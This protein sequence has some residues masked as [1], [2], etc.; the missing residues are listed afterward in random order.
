MVQKRQYSKLLI[1]MIIIST[2]IAPTL[3][4]SAK[5]FK[6]NDSID[7][8]QISDQVIRFEETIPLNIPPEYG[9]E[10]P[11]GSY[12]KVNVYGVDVGPGIILIDSGDETLAKELYKSVK[13]AFKEPILAVYLTHGHA[14]HAEGGLYFQEKGIPVYAYSYEAPIIMSGAYDP[15][16]PVPEEF[17]YTGYTPDY[18]YEYAVVADGFTIEYTPG[19]T[20]GS[21][22]IRYEG[23][24]ESYL[25][26]GDSIF[27]MP[28]MDP[29]DYSFTLSWYTAYQLWQLSSIPGYPDFTGTWMMS[30][31]YL[32]SVVGSV[33]VI[34]PGHGEEYSS[35][36]APQYLGLT[37]LVLSSLPYPPAVP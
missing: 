36:M 32:G 17:T 5:Q 15:E 24:C 1:S 23:E 11:E 37:Y 4:V 7:E 18:Y 21:V 22:S 34:C 30:V 3:S 29:L 31:G 19:H 13:K 28:G 26:T 27:E 33:D 10:I 8:Y 9:M 6:K 25:F 12:Y 16:N 14:D 20:M 2:L 35:V